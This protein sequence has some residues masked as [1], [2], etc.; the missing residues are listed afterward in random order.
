MSS[1]ILR[2]AVA[3]AGLMFVATGASAQIVISGAFDGPLSGGTPKGVELHVLEDIPDMSQYGIGSANNGGGSDGVEYTFPAGAV[4]AGTFLYVASEA[5]NFQAYFG[6]AP[7][8]TTG[9]M[10]INGDDAVELFFGTT[11]IDVFGDIN[12]DGNGEPWEYL[13][14]W[15]Y[16]VDGFGPNDGVFFDGDFTYSGANALDGCTTNDSCGST[17][18]IGT[19][20]DDEGGVVHEVMQSGYDYIP[21]SLDVH[22]GDT[23]EWHWGAGNHDVTSGANCDPDGIYFAESLDAANPVVTWIVSADAP[24]SLEYHCTVGN[25]CKS[26]MWATINVL[27]AGG[28]DADGDG[29]A[30]ES[31]NCP[32][33]SNP[34]QDDIDADGVGDACDNCPDDS[35]ENQGNSDGDSAGDAC[36]NCPYDDNEDQADSDG[37]GY[38]DACDICPGEDDDYDGN[39]NNVPDCLEVEVPEGLVISEIRIDN[40]GADTDE[41]FEL[42]GPAGAELSG[43]TYIVI[44]DGSG[45]SGVVESITNLTG[46]FDGTG[47]YL[48]AEESFTLAPDDVDQVAT[49]GFEN[50]DNVTHMVVANYYGGYD[51][52]DADDDGVL[53]STPWI[54]LADS[55][56]LVETPDSGDQYY[57]AVA[58]G[59]T[60]DGYVPGQAYRCSPDGTWTIGEFDLGLTDTPGDENTLCAAPTGAC[61]VGDTAGDYCVEDQTQSQC[62]SH[63]GGGGSNIWHEGEACVDIGCGLGDCLGD[64]DGSGTVDV[65]DLLLVISDWGNPYDVSDLLQVISD[66]GCGG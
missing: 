12:T 54:E 38:G 56:S 25:H 10:G 6:F 41:Y 43:L 36:D 46:S 30:D 49:L 59:P 27:D 19:W 64:Y 9:S 47:I 61:C 65:A 24:S 17:M 39:G 20:Q 2:A 60:V 44:G 18:P 23:I 5:T 40:D 48:V 15:A 66:W 26:G 29:I 4:S 32:N 21:A 42:K 28:Q 51:D 63:G 55:I 37:D 53:D 33:D 50:S 22:I 52:L 13:D 58:I 7:D 35:N 14:G 16:R 62:N 57:G 1:M 45:G 11:V 34:G 31:D 8:Y 3:T